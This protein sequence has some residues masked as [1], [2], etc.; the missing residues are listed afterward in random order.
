MALSRVVSEIIQCWKIS[1]PWNPSQEPINVIEIGT[2][3]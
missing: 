3:R 2:I 1:R